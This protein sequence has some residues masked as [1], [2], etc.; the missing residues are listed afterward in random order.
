[1]AAGSNGT[2]AHVHDVL[3]IGA[4][5]AGA[6][7]AYWLA[8]AG[9]V[10]GSLVEP[11]IEEEPTVPGE[12]VATVLDSAEDIVN[13]VSKVALAEARAEDAKR[14]AR[15]SRRPWWRRRRSGG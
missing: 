4:G 7:C 12:D 10:H 1:M 3:V 11:P 2:G 15:A 8:D 9:W 6:S 5:P 14:A 13:A